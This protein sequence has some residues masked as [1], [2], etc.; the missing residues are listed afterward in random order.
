[1]PLQQVETLTES[2]LAD[3]HA[4][5]QSEWWS[6][7]RS[8]DD[9]R[10][11]TENTSRIIGFVNGRAMTT[12]QVEATL[13][14]FLDNLLHAEGVRQ[15]LDQIVE[16]V[17]R[18]LDQDPQAAIVWEPV[19]LDT[20]GVELPPSIRSSWVFILRANTASGAERH[21]NSRQRMMSYRGTGDLQTRESL[22]HTWSS[23]RLTS[24]PDAPIW[25]RWISIPAN[26]WH[27][28]VVLESNWAV[29]SFHTVSQDEL[30]E[31]RPDA[32]DA[33]G[34][35]QRRYAD[36]LVRKPSVSDHFAP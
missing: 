35:V 27:Q 21:P 13:L 24:T 36:R 7:G 26:V 20:Y 32:E 33:A 25:Q 34:T 9:V 19:P 28:A 5:Y 17:E 16:R 2:Q 18:R 29:V 30:I 11:M 1:M 23:H 15:S 3:L 12:D 6:K 22:Q 14:E 10:L 4:L 31:E 8:L